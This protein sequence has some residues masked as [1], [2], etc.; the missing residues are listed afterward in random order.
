VTIEYIVFDGMHVA[1]PAPAAFPDPQ[2]LQP[3]VAGCSVSTELGR[4]A[5]PAFFSSVLIAYCL[6]YPGRSLPMLGSLPKAAAY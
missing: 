6:C 2:Q 4:V 1:W 3:R 5:M